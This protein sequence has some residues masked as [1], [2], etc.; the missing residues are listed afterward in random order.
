MSTKLSAYLLAM[1]QA[2]AKPV[3]LT[4]VDSFLAMDKVGNVTVYSGSLAYAATFMRSILSVMR[5]PASS[6]TLSDMSAAVGTGLFSGQRSS[7]FCFVLLGSDSMKPGKTALCDRRRLLTLEGHADRSNQSQRQL[8]RRPNISINKV[9]EMLGYGLARNVASGLNFLSG[10]FG[11]VVRPML[12]SVEGYDANRIIEL[13]SHK[14]A[15]DGFE[16]RSLDLG[17]A[18]D[19]AAAIAINY[20]I[21]RLIRAV[22]H[23]TGRPARFRDLQHLQYSKTSTSQSVLSWFHSTKRRARR[24]CFRSSAVYKVALRER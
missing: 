24:R 12:Q 21:N 19:A 4:E 16:I 20:Q 5:I 9:L 13:P 6:A 10:I 3:A 23:G 11:N 7:L 17:L 14:V 8:T 2:G 1:A 18:V 22:G 15:D